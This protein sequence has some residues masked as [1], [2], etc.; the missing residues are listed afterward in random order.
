MTKLLS[1]HFRCTALRIW[2]LW[3]Y[4]YT[5]IGS[6][7]A[8][9]KLSCVYCTGKASGWF[10]RHEMSDLFSAALCPDP[11]E[12]DHGS[13]TFTGDSVSDTAN[14]TCDSGFM[15]IGDAVLTCT[16]MDP[17][18]AAFSPAPPECRREYSYGIYRT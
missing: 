15:L 16:Q 12:I 5:A 4:S 17:N 6:L 2:Y 8:W 3:L 18:S 11:D 14:Y 9:P 1:Q 7:I 10:F 13:V